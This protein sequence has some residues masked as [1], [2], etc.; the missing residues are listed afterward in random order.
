M[1]AWWLAE[2]YPVFVG[3]YQLG[4]TI[5]K[6]SYATVRMGIHLLTQQRVRR[7]ELVKSGIRVRGDQHSGGRLTCRFRLSPLRWPSR[8]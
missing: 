4:E 6:G 2:T 7:A 1:L 3:G 8:R 5:G